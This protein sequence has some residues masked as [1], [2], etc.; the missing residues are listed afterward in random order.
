MKLN[1]HTLEEALV[2]RSE[3]KRELLESKQA[4]KKC[5]KVGSES[6]N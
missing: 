2:F 6:I 4:N 1:F 3:L 5:K